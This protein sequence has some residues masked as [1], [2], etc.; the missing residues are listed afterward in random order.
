M[1]FWGLTLDTTSCIFL[2][3]SIGLCVDYSAHVGHTFMTLSGSRS[4]RTRVTLEEIGPA[5]FHGGFS[6]FMAF[7]LLSNSESYVF[8]TFFKVIFR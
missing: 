5:V 3:I 8:T 6:T 4:E 2:I 1:H 7:A